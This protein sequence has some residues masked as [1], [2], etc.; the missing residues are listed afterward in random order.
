MAT[1][2]ASPQTRISV[3]DARMT[4]NYTR[5]DYTINNCFGFL[6]GT[7]T[8]SGCA[9]QSQKKVP[10]A[11]GP[12]VCSCCDAPHIVRMTYPQTPVLH[13]SLS[14]VARSSFLS[15]VHRFHLEH[16]FAGSRCF[17]GVTILVATDTKVAGRDLPTQPRIHYGHSKK[18]SVLRKVVNLHLRFVIF[19]WT[20]ISITARYIPTQKIIKWKAYSL[21]T[22]SHPLL[23]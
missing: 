4:C 23:W 22:N 12:S 8:F 1:C 20:G 10:I 13:I 7:S 15:L 6:A 14:V 19:Y 9:S 18:I 17:A 3:V 21:F 2:I 11:A 16:F 5:R